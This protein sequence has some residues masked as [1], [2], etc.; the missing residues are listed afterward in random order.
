M[1]R[2]RRL[3]GRHKSLAAGLQLP[4]V[5]FLRFISPIV[6]QRAN[7]DYL[8]VLDVHAGYVGIVTK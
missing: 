8:V 7:A 2:Q 3:E 1:R 4:G 5:E 6:M